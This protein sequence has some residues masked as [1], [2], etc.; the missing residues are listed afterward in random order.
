MASLKYTANSSLQT[1]TL[2]S[3]YTAGSGSMTL[4][5]GEG[6]RLPATGDYWLTYND[7][8][9]TVRIF[10]VTARSTDT[11]TVVADST[12]GNGDAN[13]ASGET[14]TWALTV[15]ALNQLKADIVAAGSLVLLE[16]QTASSSATLNFTSCVSSTYDTY[17]IVLDDV[18]PA[19]NTVKL[20]MR[21]STN[22]GSSYDSSS[23]YGYASLIWRAGGSATSGEEG[24]QSQINIID[25]NM[26]NDA[27]W[28]GLTGVL[29][30]VNPNSAKYKQVW[31]QVAYIEANPNRIGLQTRGSYE[32]TTAVNAFQFYFSS[33]NI[34][35][36]TIRVY[37]VAK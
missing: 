21:M 14:L 5:S 36:G 27:N 31:G 25:Y 15:S 1:V 34:A 9:G 20:Q 24:G 10:K 2:G 28:P 23:I 12:E 29:Y 11:L 18:L 37:G 26:A 22:G 13:I 16:T 35:S 6:S 8:A 30:L 17:M 32:S 4:T 19:S 7:G 33:G 3:A